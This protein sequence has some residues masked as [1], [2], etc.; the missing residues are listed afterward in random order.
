MGIGIV[1][2]GVLLFVSV[3]RL[4]SYDRQLKEWAE[5]LTQ[6]DEYSNLRLGTSV[7]S[8]AFLRC[9]RAMNH[10]LENGQQAR[11][12]LENMSRELKYTVSCVSHDIRTPLTGAMGYLQLL[13]NTP[14]AA[15]QKEYIS[16]IRR[17]ME[18]LEG[19]LEELFLFS[20][21]SNEEYSIECSE[22]APFPVL[23]DVLAGFYYRLTAAGVEPAVEFGEEERGVWG[24]EEALRRIFSNLLQNALRYGSGRLEIKRQGNRITFTNPV[25]QPE[26][27][28]AD[29]L[30]DR[31]Y[32]SD[33]ARHT[34]GAG[35]GLASV[36][37]LMEKMGGSAAAA[38]E[39]GQLTII[40][41]FKAPGNL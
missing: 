39:A 25:K 29:R 19:L 24:S 33:A 27:L 41:E 30:F 12:R 10:R 14:D 8:R 16:I 38:V 26:T 21:L 15:R 7:R 35:L 1:I 37:G 23:C 17:R 36:K 11:I 32:R 9:C 4:W 40:L 6:T 18:D 34:G 3:L 31:F 20:K 13:E 2:M 22:T 5:Q 28:D